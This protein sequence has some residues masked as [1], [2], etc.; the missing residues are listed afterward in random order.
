[1]SVSGLAPLV[2]HFQILRESLQG[3]C[4]TGKALSSL[5]ILANHSFCAEAATIVNL[6][7]KALQRHRLGHRDLLPDLRHLNHVFEVSGAPENWTPDSTL[8]GILKEAQESPDQ[9]WTRRTPH[10]VILPGNRNLSLFITPEIFPP[11][12]WTRTFLAGLL[13]TGNVER[14]QGR[15]GIELGTG[16]GV[17][18]MS[19]LLSGAACMLGLDIHPDSPGVAGINACLNLP[20]DVRPNLVLQT[21]DLFDSLD[22]HFVYADFIVGC[23]PQ[24]PQLRGKGISAREAADVYPGIGEPEDLFGFG[25]L[26]RGLRQASSHL[27]EGGWVEFMVSGRMGLETA[28]DLFRRHGF[29]PTVTHRT[30]I[31]QDA[32]PPLESFAALEK[33][34]GIRFQFYQSGS[35]QPLSARE[36]IAVEVDRSKIEHDLFV[37]RGDP[38]RWTERGAIRALFNPEGDLV[39]R[40]VG[41]GYTGDPGAEKADLRADIANHYEAVT[42]IRPSPEIV[43]VGP[44]V[45]EL[46]ATLLRAAV[47]QGELVAF[48]GKNFGRFHRVREVEDQYRYSQVGERWEKIESFITDSAPKVAVFN[49]TTQ[50]YDDFAGLR[51]VAE[52]ATRRGT[53]LVTAGRFPRRRTDE[54]YPLARLF[55]EIPT[56]AENLVVLN[57]LSRQ[58]SLTQGLLSFAL[59]PSRAL[60]EA[61]VR[62]GEVTFSRAAT[63][64]QIAASLVF[65]RISAGRKAITGPSLPLRPVPGK[66]ELLQ[67]GEWSHYPTFQRHRK[68]HRD[69]IALDFGESEWPI[70]VMIQKGILEAVQEGG[71]RDLEIKMIGAARRYLEETRGIRG[72]EIISG[73]GVLPLQFAALRALTRRPD[74]LRVLVPDV[75]YDVHFP[76]IE[77]AGALAIR[78]NTKGCKIDLS[79]LRSLAEHLRDLVLLLIQPTNPGG[80]YYSLDEI[81]G[82]AVAT[83]GRTIF[84]DE[85]FGLTGTPSAGPR[86]SFDPIARK[87]PRGPRVVTFFG[88]SKEIGQAGGLRAGFAAT[89]DRRL[90]QR[91]RDEVL[92]PIDPMATGASIAGFQNWRKITTLHRNFL[93]DRKRQLGQFLSEVGISFESAEG[94]FSFLADLSPLYG[95]TWQ[96]TSVT[97]ENIAE[98]FERAGVVIKPPGWGG[99]EQIRLVYSIQRLTDA[100]NRIKSFLSELSPL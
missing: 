35:Q 98:I 27:K 46:M 21:S 86:V 66:T 44:S 68:T 19:L 73:G 57:D 16:S 63:L 43:F 24:V 32:D 83:K 71:L 25:L 82:I 61:M 74:R 39:P 41:I 31:P 72:A 37:I 89:S 29:H 84:A 42:G 94:G 76:M 11:G 23:L 47:P 95:R 26:A 10:S 99:T 20:C 88:L 77:A 75:A 93:E 59:V 53:L 65:Q 7:Q 90:A 85:V 6:A 87:D 80:K 33:N 100:I 34:E 15:R 97:R 49:L 18:A 70:P 48:A 60:Y 96:G 22:P 40:K 78:L 36:A 13:K 51:R 28:L 4:L 58:L 56:L 45:Q 5:R 69:P 3:G 2:P 17:V 54:I 62:W 14:Y 64:G 92:A 91:I 67:G 81:R 50:N 38:Y 8:P 79:H 30:R 52:A 12:N 55:Q 1:M 9:F